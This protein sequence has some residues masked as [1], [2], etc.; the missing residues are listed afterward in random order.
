MFE[1]L[2]RVDNMLL[3]EG[4]SDPCSPTNLTVTNKIDQYNTFDYSNYQTNLGQIR[5][6]YS[7]ELGKYENHC[8]D[9]CTH[10]KTLLHEQSRTRP[11]SEQEIAQMISIIRKKF[12]PIQLQLKQSTCEAVMILRSRSLD[13][14]FKTFFFK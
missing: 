8:D 4:I 13:A 1:Q 3:A 12:S 14:R 11:I 6:T 7:V 9:F 2:M 10:V 5:Q